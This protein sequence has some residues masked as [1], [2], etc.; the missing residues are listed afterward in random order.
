MVLVEIGDDLYMYFGSECGDS[1]ETTCFM[2]V[3]A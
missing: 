3:K 1:G 2:G